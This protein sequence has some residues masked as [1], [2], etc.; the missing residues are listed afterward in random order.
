MS[1][2]FHTCRSKHQ[3]NALHRE[4]RDRHKHT[5]THARTHC[6]LQGDGARCHATLPTNGF[7]TPL[8]PQD[9]WEKAL[10]L[11]IIRPPL[12]EP[13]SIHGCLHTKV[14][15]EETVCRSVCPVI[16]WKTSDWLCCITHSISAQHKTAQ[17]WLRL[18][19]FQGIFLSPSCLW[20]SSYLGFTFIVGMKC[21]NEMQVFD[22]FV[23]DSCLHHFSMKC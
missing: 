3:T 23:K 8:L 19:M 11:I 14:T 22:V 15:S 21:K 20:M 4:D 9:I 6:C 10:K 17:Q 18:T 2:F 13:I 5:H 7:L 12:W 16:A 1:R